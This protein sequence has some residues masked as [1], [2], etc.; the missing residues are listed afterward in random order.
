[1]QIRPKKYEEVSQ[2][3]YQYGVFAVST[4]KTYSKKPRVST[5]RFKNF[6]EKFAENI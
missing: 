4:D 1:M 6:C 5:K 2:E 3:L